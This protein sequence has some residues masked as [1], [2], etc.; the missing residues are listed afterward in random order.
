MNACERYEHLMNFVTG[1]ISDEEEWDPNREIR[2]KEIQW[3]LNHQD[4]CTNPQHNSTGWGEVLDECEKKLAERFRNAIDDH[5]RQVRGELTPDSPHHWAI[6]ALKQVGAFVNK[7]HDLVGLKCVLTYNEDA[8]D[9][10]ETT[11]CGVVCGIIVGASVSSFVD[12]EMLSESLTLTIAH[13]NMV[14]LD[15]NGDTKFGRISGAQRWSNEIPLSNR[16]KA[17]RLIV[18]FENQ[19]DRHIGLDGTL[20]I[21]P[22]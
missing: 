19:L 12:M 2:D 1:P 4:T 8:T 22:Q 16:D 5:R 13:A 11:Q 9:G 14:M 21:L 20:V 7:L 6:E 10:D 18:S 17:W 15:D 3:M